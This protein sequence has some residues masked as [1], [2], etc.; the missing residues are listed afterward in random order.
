MKVLF[1]SHSFPPKVNGL[2][3]NGLL[4]RTFEHCREW[5]AAG[6]QVTVITTMPCQRNGDLYTGYKNAMLYR[7]QFEGIEVIRLWRFYPKKM[8]FKKSQSF[9]YHFH[10]FMFF[11]LAFRLVSKM[12]IHPNVV[13]SNFSNIAES[14]LGWC[15]S[16]RLHRPLILE[17]LDVPQKSSS[18]TTQAK[19]KN[20]FVRKVCDFLLNK[21]SHIVTSTQRLANTINNSNL[22]SAKIS[23]ISN[24]VDVRHLF[25]VHKPKEWVDHLT[26]Q[27]RWIVGYIPSAKNFEQAQQ[28]RD[29]FLRVA[30]ILSTESRIVLLWITDTSEF[31]NSNSQ[32]ENFSNVKIFSTFEEN[33][34]KKI[35]S[36]VDLC[37]F[38]QNN[39]VEL[40]II[41]SSKIYQCMAM[42]KPILISA[43][44]ETAE[45]ID[46]A[47]C[48]W[49]V[50][51]QD[52]E[53]IGQVIRRLSHSPEL[54]KTLGEN[55]QRYV[56]RF[57]K[58]SRIAQ[59]YAALLQDI[60]VNHNQS[61]CA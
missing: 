59:Q 35:W 60:A 31:T 39:N 48:G 36:L 15:I 6:H 37:L 20:F 23:V 55:G 14:L 53:A 58:R 27:D 33:D 29:I 19:Y 9:L 40:E 45:L 47:D 3:A 8:L 30:Q 7:E 46:K 43:L 57:C 22:V 1:L 34:I 13:I 28:E 50:E 17:V 32:F 49:I 56:R 54:C 16:K 12:Y 10:L 26:L 18:N 5:V 24:S 4:D 61:N 41:V 21:A 38:I 25:P 11:L 2:E 51:P 42:Q 44:G 52:V